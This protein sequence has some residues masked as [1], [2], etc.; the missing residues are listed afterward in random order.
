MISSTWRYD[1]VGLLAAKHYGIPYIDV[2]P[3]L[4]KQ[5][6]NQ[7]ILQWISAH[8]EVERFAVID[9]E[10]DELDDLPLFQPSDKIGLDPQ[11]A[12]GVVAYLN[13]QT[14][15]DMRRNVLARVA[16]NVAAAFGGHKG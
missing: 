11:T 2:T 4:P 14:D 5:A 3:D 12:D 1:P 13:G 6:R 7:E 10:D 16:Q 8:P 15:R 9:D